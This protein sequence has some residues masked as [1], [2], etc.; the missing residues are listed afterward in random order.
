MEISGHF[1]HRDP[2][3][4]NF[5]TAATSITHTSHALDAPRP[6]HLTSIQALPC[7]I[8][9]AAAT[10]WIGIIRSVAS[11]KDRSGGIIQHLVR[12]ISKVIPILLPP[13]TWHRCSSAHAEPCYS[14][15]LM[16][17]K[18]NYGQHHRLIDA[19]PSA[20]NQS[21]WQ[22]TSAM[23]SC[24]AANHLDNGNASVTLRNLSP[25]MGGKLAQSKA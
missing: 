9:P 2:A 8:G 6:Q 11:G 4:I 25:T 18:T 10:W 22:L 23:L 5:P 16:N 24:L 14:G 15:S 3:D 1:L 7:V 20:S 17:N 12:A 13:V 19:M 21:R